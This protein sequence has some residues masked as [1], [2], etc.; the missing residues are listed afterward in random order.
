[1]LKKL[2]GAWER[3]YC[4]M[5]IWWETAPQKWWDS[6]TKPTTYSVLKT[7]YYVTKG[8]LQ[9][10]ITSGTISYSHTYLMGGGVVSQDWRVWL[11]R[12]GG[13]VTEWCGL[14]D[15]GGGGDWM[16]WLTRLVLCKIKIYFSTYIMSDPPPP[17]P[18]YDLLDN[19]PNQF[20]V[21]RLHTRKPWF[22]TKHCL[23]YSV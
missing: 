17:D 3:D 22:C 20:T 7:Y 18:L 23:V 10:Y 1:M 13:G 4:D 11:A 8:S 16:V 5:I 21:T 15:L 14:Q 2:G 9:Q 6:N 12:L 19:T